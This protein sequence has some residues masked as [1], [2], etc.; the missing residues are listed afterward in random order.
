MTGKKKKA[1]CLCRAKVGSAGRFPVGYCCC[2]PDGV[3]HGINQANSLL[4]AA[5]KTTSTH[6]PR[7]VSER[8][9]L[10]NA[11][12]INPRGLRLAEFPGCSP[13]ILGALGPY[14]P[15]N[16]THLIGVSLGTVGAAQEGLLGLLLVSCSLIHS[17]NACVLGRGLGKEGR[18][19]GMKGMVEAAGGGRIISLLA[20]STR[21]LFWGNI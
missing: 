14:P 10:T 21:H 2:F 13:Q 3:E 20:Q 1:S 8:P 19:A 7:G 4:P 15:V 9:R 6:N 11:W 17:L 18:A 12:K 5:Y 16:T